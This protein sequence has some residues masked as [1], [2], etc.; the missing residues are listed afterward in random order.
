MKRYILIGSL[1]GLLMPLLI[2]KLQETAPLSNYDFDYL[3]FW[4]PAGWIFLLPARLCR[5]ELCTDIILVVGVIF[6]GWAILGGMI[7]AL[8]YWI[9]KKIISNRY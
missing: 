9:R 2:V 5:N 8:I 6:T 7:G 4:N 1:L 3:I